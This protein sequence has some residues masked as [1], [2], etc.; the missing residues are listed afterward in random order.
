MSKPVN[1][2]V[3][4]EEVGGDVGRLIR[5]FVKKCKKERI[6]ENYLDRMYYEKPSSKRRKE[7][8]KKKRNAQKAEQQRNKKLSI[9]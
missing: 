1:V 3:S 8:L 4:L 5:K 2:E 6:L 7:K 9:R